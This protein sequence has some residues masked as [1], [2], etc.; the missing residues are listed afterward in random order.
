MSDEP[1]NL[2][3]NVES[4]A[5]NSADISKE[6][7]AVFKKPVINSADISKGKTAILKKCPYRISYEKSTTTFGNPND[8]L[9]V[10]STC[11]GY[12]SYSV[13]GNPIACNVYLS[14]LEMW[15]QKDKQSKNERT[16][17]NNA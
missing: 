7:T 17:Q 14:L 13:N 1:K 12:G 8:R 15:A 2:E 11:A 16:E 10:C 3:D 5:N 4:S 9:K 6:K